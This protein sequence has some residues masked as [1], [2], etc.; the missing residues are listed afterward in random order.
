MNTKEISDINAAVAQLIAII[1]N[2]HCKRI[3]RS[4]VIGYIGELLIRRKL[5]EEGIAS[6]NIEHKG[7]QTA[8]DLLFNETIRIDVKTSTLKSEAKGLPNYWG[9]ALK[10]RKA[11][12][13]TVKR[14]RTYPTHYICIALTKDYAVE[15]YY[16]IKYSELNKFPVSGI[17][18]FKNVEHGYIVLEKPDDILN[19]KNENFNSFIKICEE[20]TGNAVNILKPNQNLSKV[21][22]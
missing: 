17:A 5:L 7:N 9:W 18:Q 1:N 14:K 11:Y 22:V 8:Y 20:L 21:L 19:G 2:E 16:I 13:I 6:K 10:F 12:T 15:N 4:N 3:N